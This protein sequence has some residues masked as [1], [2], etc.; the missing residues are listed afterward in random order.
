MRRR[1]H[2]KDGPHHG[3]EVHYVFGNLAA[4]YPGELPKFDETDKAISTAMMKAWAAFA[5][6]GEPNGPGLVEWQAYDASADN[7]LEFGDCIR[8]D[9]GWRSE[10]LNFL[11]AFF[12]TT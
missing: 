12:G 1:A 11:D 10:Q 5:A 3:Q 6:T 8:A 4:S 9:A 2:R 7:Y